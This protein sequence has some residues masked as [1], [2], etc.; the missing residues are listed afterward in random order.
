MDVGV[1]VVAHEVAGLP[2]AAAFVLGA[3][4][5]PTDPVA[6]AAIIRRLPSGGAARRVRRAR[7][8]DRRRARRLVRPRDLGGCA[9][10]PSCLLGGARLLLN[11]ALFLLI[12]LEM[13]DVLGRFGD[14]EEGGRAGETLLL[15][16][17]VIGLRMAWM[18]LVAPLVAPRRRRELVVLGWSGMR[19]GV[20]LAAALAVPVMASGQA[21]VPARTSRARRRAAGGIGTQAAR[22]IGRE[23]DLDER[24]AS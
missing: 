10:A 14:G 8:S 3:V 4:V 9:P 19:G 20:S 11:S 21:R 5:G 12:G 15:A 1:A 23:L 2:W 22:E 6:A 7:G 18:M 13:Q 24:R 16:A 17:V